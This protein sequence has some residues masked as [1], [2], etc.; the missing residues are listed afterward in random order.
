M[1][2]AQRRGL[3]VLGSF[4]DAVGWDQILERIGAWAGQG[5]GRCV[6]TCNVHG[7]TLG[8]QD[9]ALREAVNAAD[10]AVP[11]GMPLAWLLRS[12][13][14]AGQERIDGP[15][16]M[17]RCCRLASEQGLPVYLF[18]STPG[19][20]ALLEQRLK[21]AF[22][23]L[24][25]CGACSPPFGGPEVLDAPALIE[26]INARSPALVFVGL[27]C[28]KQDT[29][30]R[31]NRGRVNAVM[32]GVGAAFDFHA[33]VLRRAPAWMQDCG[34]EWAFRLA[35]EPGRLHRRYLFSNSSFLWRWLRGTL[36]GQ[37]E[38]RP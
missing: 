9:A 4:I 14:F 26:G 7:V 2:G 31:R 6:C 30:M 18:G 22:P 32:L 15:G 29:W 24:E 28:P 17:W 1:A 35:Q 36:C 20:L 37:A 10:L 25:V 38:E 8:R 3:R 33:G 11:D 21:E 19:T 27:G 12:R 13:G 23:G 5:K 34:L 16:L